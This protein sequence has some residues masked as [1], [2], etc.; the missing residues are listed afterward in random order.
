MRTLAVSLLALGLVAAGCGSKTPENAAPD[1]D[2]T[3]GTAAT[4]GGT[5]GG[6]HG[7]A[8]GPGAGGSSGGVAGSG[9]GAGSSGGVAGSGDGGAIGS[10]GGGGSPE[11][12]GAIGSG[13][14]DGGSSGAGS[15][16][17]AGGVPDAA[18]D[19]PAAPTDGGGIPGHEWV[20]PCHPDWTKAQCC[21]HYCTCMMTNCAAKAPANC[22]ATC[23]APGN[24][25]NLKCK[26]EQCFESLDPRYPMDHNSHCGHA[27]E[28]AHCQGIIP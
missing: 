9:D 20:L 21:M 5:S 14:S 3:G 12:G 7:G 26:V 11:T 17:A 2:G 23:T 4:T 18:A 28:A 22:L 8:K 10:G 15:G 1:P 25:W 24:N 6:G 27:T 13:G 19:A 16:G